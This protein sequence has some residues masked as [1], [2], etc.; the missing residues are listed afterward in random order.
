MTQSTLDAAEPVLGSGSA[1]LAL[2]NEES[3][4]PA[5]PRPRVYAASRASIP[6]R[7]ALWRAL[8]AQGACIVSSWI[9]ASEDEPD[10]DLSTLWA[11]IEVEIRSCD[12][13]VLYAR[14]EDFPLKGALVEVGMALG[15]GKPVVVVLE[16]CELNPSTLRPLGS[17]CRHPDIR[18]E[19]DLRRA[20]LSPRDA[21]ESG[22]ALCAEA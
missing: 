16:D 8:R 18:F 9:D 5:H 20:V 2:R 3:T 6:Q 12:R 4:P 11:R 13:L 14:P 17:W 10:T 19:H 1:T 21:A 22:K 15:M 7:P